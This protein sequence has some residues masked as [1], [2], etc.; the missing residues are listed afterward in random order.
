[1][2][3]QSVRKH[4]YQQMHVFTRTDHFLADVLNILVTISTFLLQCL[5][6]AVYASLKMGTSPMHLENQSKKTM[7]QRLQQPLHQSMLI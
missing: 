6:K 2:R 4:V 3:K 1:M 7:L 5:V